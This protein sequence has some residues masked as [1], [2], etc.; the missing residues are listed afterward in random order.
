[1]ADK[2]YIV[3]FKPPALGAIQVVVASTVKVHDEHLTFCNA[4]GD[5]AALFLLE[6]VQSWSELPD[7]DRED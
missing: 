4:K 6:I 1:M 5:L 2:T 7:L 3:K